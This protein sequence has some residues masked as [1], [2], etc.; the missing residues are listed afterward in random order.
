MGADR[1]HIH[2]PT[3]VLIHTGDSQELE[4]VKH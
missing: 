2:E 3:I 4:R 1:L